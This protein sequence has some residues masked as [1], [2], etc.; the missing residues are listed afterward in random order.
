MAESGKMIYPDQYTKWLRI[1]ASTSGKE[2]EKKSEGK[3]PLSN[4]VPAGLSISLPEG[5]SSSTLPDVGLANSY[6]RLALKIPAPFSSLTRLGNRGTGSSTSS[7]LPKPL[8]TTAHT[9]RHLRFQNTSAA[10]LPITSLMLANACGTMGTSAVTVRSSLSNVM[11]TSLTVW[12]PAG[13]FAQVYWTSDTGQDFDDLVD[14]SIPTGIT[15]TTAARYRP[16]P[17]SLASFW[18]GS[19][20]AG[21]TLLNL[22]CSVGSIVDVSIASRYSNALPN[23]AAQTVITAVLGNV[24]YLALDGPAS[25]KYIPVGL[26]TTS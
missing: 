4:G 8:R 2:E 18:Q 9:T 6:L 1:N 3:I 23:F 17:K 14:V 20:A 24:Y 22:S 5:G 10:L 25:N 26:P 11:L 19:G 13:G 15:D 16:S 7:S 21:V 12:P